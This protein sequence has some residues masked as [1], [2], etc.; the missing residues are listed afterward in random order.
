MDVV[1]DDGP[2]DGYSAADGPD[3]SHE[4]IPADEAAA[5]ED[6]HR[7]SARSEAGDVTR[8]EDG[9]GEA[10]ER[11]SAGTGTRRTRPRNTWRS[12]PY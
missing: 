9:D 8:D 10:P 2:D 12:W 7:Q 5:H 3:G 6:A 1:P 11:A 4:D